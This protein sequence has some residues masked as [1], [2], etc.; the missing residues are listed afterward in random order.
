MAELNDKKFG[1]A[2]Q[3]IWSL[4]GVDGCESISVIRYDFGHMAA[5]RL[6]KEARRTAQGKLEN[7]GYGDWGLLEHLNN[8]HA[9]GHSPLGSTN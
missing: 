5:S 3:M 1:C 2:V 6:V 7:R 9:G 8:R 4:R